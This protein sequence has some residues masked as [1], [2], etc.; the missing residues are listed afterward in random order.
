MSDINKEPQKGKR[1]NKDLN[2]S[3]SNLN[4]ESYDTIRHFQDENGCFPNSTT[5]F[6]MN[7]ANRG[8]ISYHLLLEAIKNKG[9]EVSWVTSNYENGVRKG[10]LELDTYIFQ[11]EN[12]FLKKVEKFKKI[13][14]NV[15]V[16]KDMIYVVGSMNILHK[17][18]ELPKHIRDI[19]E[20]CILATKKFPTVSIISRD[21]GGFFLNEVKINTNISHELD[22][23]YGTGFSKFHDL[24]INK[25]VDTNKGLTLL[26]GEPGT[27]KSSYIRKL[28]YDL[29][30]KTNKKILI[31][32][33]N[34]ISCLLDPEF[35]TFLLESVETEEYEEF[36]SDFLEEE[37]E[38]S[39]KISKGMI[40]ILEDA[41]SVLLKR[42]TFGDSQGTSNILNMTSGLLNDIF[43]IQIIATYNTDDKNIDPAIQRSQ[44][45]VAKRIFKKLN[46][47]DSKNLGLHIGLDEEVIEREIT[48]EMTV[49]EVYSLIEKDDDDILIDKSDTNRAKGN[50]FK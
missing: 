23:H 27:G 46:L 34:L 36:E 41:E 8:I 17:E 10:V 28:I 3:V 24:L 15:D 2:I 4:I 40:M 29:M 19:V 22:S 14:E 32:P 12:I 43:G 25:L 18:E 38:E 45:M 1:N 35:N 33:N 42:D 5:L 6:G 47:E 48:K 44:R 7:V 16:H 9:G 50:L 39:D 37:Q 13:P 11:I 49:A 26:H 20:S 30:E 31:I 21:Q